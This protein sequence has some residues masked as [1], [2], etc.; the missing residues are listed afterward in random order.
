MK[1]NRI[2]SQSEMLA[3]LSPGFECDYSSGDKVIQNRFVKVADLKIIYDNKPRFDPNQLHAPYIIW[4]AKGGPLLVCNDDNLY[5][6]TRL[7]TL[8][9]RA[10][11]MTIKSLDEI[12]DGADR[13]A[14]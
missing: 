4:D 3:C 5:R 6:L 12:H 9:V 10:G 2:E 8:M 13:K 11:V 7:E 14:C 1:I